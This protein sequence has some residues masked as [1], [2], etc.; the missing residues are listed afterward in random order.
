MKTAIRYLRFSRLGQSHSSIE[1][2]EMLTDNWLE[3]NG[4]ELV[5]SFI[6]RGKSARTFDRPDFK[7][8]RMFIEKYSKRVDYLVVDQMDRFSREAGEALVLVKRL[9]KIYSI[10]IVSVTEGITFDYETPGSFFRAGLQFLLAEDDNINRSIKVRGGIYTAKAKEGRFIYG[11]A[12]FGYKKVGEGKDKHLEV[13]DTEA[14]IIKYIYDA[15]LHG[16]PAYLIKKKARKLGLKRTGNSTIDNILQNPIYTGLQKVKPF[17][18]HPGGLFPANHEPIIDRITWLNVQE[19]LKKPDKTRTIIDD[20]IP[21]RGILKCHCGNPLSGAPSRGRAGNYYYYYKCR[22]SK[23]NNISAIKAHKQLSKIFELMS[24]KKDAVLKIKEKSEEMI[25]TEV[26]ANQ[27]KIQGY[28]LSL[29]RTKEKLISL[30]E[31]WIENSIDRETYDRWYATYNKDIMKL[32][33][34]ISVLNTDKTKIYKAFYENLN[35]LTNLESLY[36]RLDTLEKRELV[37]MVFDSKLYYENGAYRT[38]YM[39]QIFSHNNL[40]MRELN[41]LHYQK[42]TGFHK[43]IPSSRDDWIRT[44]DHTHPMRVRYQ[45]APHPEIGLQKYK[46]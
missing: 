25:K 42:K 21:L 23:H 34:S 12:P 28:K 7:K 29:H 45:T 5:D 36:K 8:L 30:E 39:A 44:S 26:N 18:E 38:T 11:H 9:Q 3:F 33:A 22:H 16:T 6:D 27:H 2:Q 35:Y 1:R 4:V 17:K 31:K 13:V 37:N 24:L 32:D 14:E 40:K 41:L 43:E 19:K 10:Q 15:Y 46:F 20:H